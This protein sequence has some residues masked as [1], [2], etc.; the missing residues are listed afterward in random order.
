M[1]IYTQ[2]DL[3]TA[4]LTKEHL[5][6]RK[7]G[8]VPTMGALHEGH[9]SLVA[10]AKSENDF[11][12]ASI[13][14][15]PT[16]F[17]NPDDLKNYPRTPEADLEKLQMAGTDLVFQPEINQIYGEG[18]QNKE[19]V[20]LGNLDKVLEAEHRPGHFKG[21]VQVVSRLFDIVHPDR[22]YFGEKDYQQLAVIRKMTSDLKY[23]SEIIGCETKRE[24]NGLAMSSRNLLLTA[25]ER[26]SARVIYQALQF[27][28]ANWKLNGAKAILAE[29][30]EMINSLVPL[31]VEYIAI[32]DSKML[33]PIESFSPN[34]EA[35]VFAAVFCGR[36]RLIDNM[37][38]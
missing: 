30:K 32:A 22:A 8:F 12:V 5:K 33:L 9:I 18:M 25:D 35:R 20:D 11:V 3:L 13:F 6:G 26:E 2:S 4:F 14:V 36:V 16:Q 28:K 38:I 21:V 37:A 34:L 24:K 19:Q 15:N 17:N 23:K 29:A 7:L 27:I 10:K 1:E 31:K